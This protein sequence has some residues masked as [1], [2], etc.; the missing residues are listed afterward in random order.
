MKQIMSRIK[1][2][3]A[4]IVT[5][6]KQALLTFHDAT[7]ILSATKTKN[8]MWRR[9]IVCHTYTNGQ[10]NYVTNCTNPVHQNTILYITR[11]TVMKPCCIELTLWV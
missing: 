11:S 9:R 3:S 1:H 4:F 10:V 5:Y 7:I 2:T 6:T 8:I